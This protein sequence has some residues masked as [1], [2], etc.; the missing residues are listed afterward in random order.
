[1]KAIDER[2]TKLMAGLNQRVKDLKQEA[3]RYGE[4]HYAG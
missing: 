3:R 1:V 2:I 4:E